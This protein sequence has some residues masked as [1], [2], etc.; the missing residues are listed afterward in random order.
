MT[1]DAVMRH[2]SI[3][4]VVRP[5][6]IQANIVHMPTCS[7]LSARANVKDFRPLYDGVAPNPHGHSADD[8]AWGE[9]VG[10]LFAWMRDTFDQ[11][12]ED[13]QYPGQYGDPDLGDDTD[14]ITTL[15]RGDA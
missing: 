9:A 6:F 13:D 2:W 3:D 15:K 8:L 1:R 5:D 12:G 11:V 4:L 7:E 10:T 14:H